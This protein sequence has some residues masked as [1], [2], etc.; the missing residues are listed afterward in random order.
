[1]TVSLLGA[2]RS[3]GAPAGSRE[4]PLRADIQGLRAVAVALVVV[5]HL[6][7]GLLPGGFVGVDVFLVISGFLITT[8]LVSRPPRSW[9][10]LAAFWAR[11]AR[12]LLPAALLVLTATL[13]ATRVVAPETLWRT[14]ASEVI[15]SAL[16]VQNW[17]LATSSVDYLAAESAASPV[18]HYWSLSVEEQFYL[19]WPLVVSGLVLLSLRAGS[20]RALVVP[21]G[22]AA[23]VLASFAWSVHATAVQPAGAYFV[24]PTRVWELGAGAVLAVLVADRAGERRPRSAAVRSALAA[25]GLAAVLVAATTYSSA[26]PFPGWQATLPVLGTVAVIAARAEPGEAWPVRLLAPRPVQYLGDVSYSVYL[27]HWP[28]VV[29][30][31][32]VSGGQLGRLDRAAV[33]VLSVVLAGLTKTLVE[34]RF[35]AARGAPGTRRSLRLAGAG[36]ALV[37]GLGALQLLEVTRL[38]QRAEAEVAAA[39]AA[40][41][42]CFGAAALAAGADCPPL[43]TGKPVPPP[44]QAVNDTSEAYARGCFAASPFAEVRRCTFG[45]PQG[46]VSIALVGNSHAG[47]WL[48]ALEAVAEQRGWRITTFLA[49]ECTANRTPVQ[50][51]GAEE[52]AGCLGWADA[53]LE[54]TSGDGFDLVVT[55]Q[56]NGR[57]AVGRSYADSRPAWL[58]GYREVV[59]GWERAG[60]YV[61]VL[62]DTATPGA[63]LESVPDCLAEHPDDPLECSGPRSAWVPDDPLAQAV[64]EA[65]SERLTVLDLNDRLCDGAVCLPVVG[66]VTVYSDASHLTATFAATLARD[67]DPAL[68]AAV[69]RAT[70]G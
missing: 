58:E 63:T 24:T 30:V 14:T 26:T 66:G 32:F 54:E 57:P 51:D 43:G 33:L 2:R 56:R 42:P 17:R 8:H 31:P 39:L 6:W 12:R 18:Q 25:T 19:F 62:H 4:R 48:P 55:S 69:G 61:L 37:V 52:R 40:G 27:W 9:A 16:Y 38:E 28:L 22:M 47:H 10:D 45:D 49:S 35:R 44:A 68:V 46:T 50:W 53:V 36:M 11:R 41:G 1:M 3:P 34:D 7:P 67:L 59:S 23:V 65:G 15:A 64:G 60:T 20:R 21:A 29:L 13:V 70:A 5:Y